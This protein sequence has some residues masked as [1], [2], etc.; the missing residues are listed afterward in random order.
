MVADFAGAEKPPAGDE[1]ENAAEPRLAFN[2]RFAPWKT[3]LER[4]AEVAKLN[5]DMDEPPPGT[6]NYYDKSTYS[7]KE[8]LDIIN[9][10]LI[11]K[12]FILVRRDRFLVVANF[13]R[14]PVPPNL[15]PTVALSELPKRGKNEYLSV[16]IPL[17][18][19]DAKTASEEIKDLL[20]PY[21]Q[22]KA[23]P[24]V[25]SN[26]LIVTDLASHVQAIYEVLEGM[27][28]VT[29][30]KGMTVRSFKLLHI[31]ATEAERMLRDL[32]SL[33]A[34]GAAS[35]STASEPQQGAAARSSRQNGDDTSRRDWW[36]R[37]R[38][39]DDRFSRGGGGFPGSGDFT[40][41]GE[42]G[43]GEPQAMYEQF[44][45]RR[46]RGGRGSDGGESGDQQGASRMTLT[47]DPRQNTLLVTCSVEDMRR[48]E[49]VIK[50]IDVEVSADARGDYLR[51]DNVPQ[52][53]VYPLE[54]AD[55]AVVAEVLYLT[56]PGLVVRDDAKT[57]GVIVYAT[58]TEQQQVRNIV[59]QLDGQV[60]DSIA[61]L[62]LRHWDAAAAATSLK[63]LFE[64]TKVDPPTIEADSNGRRLM[65]R[66]TPDQVSQIKRLLADMGEDGSVAAP[67][68]S[69]TGPVRSILPQGRSAAEILAIVKQ[70]YPD[71][72]NSSIR[73]VEPSAIGVPSFQLRQIDA[74]RRGGSPQFRRVAPPAGPGPAA[75][76]SSGFRPESGGDSG[77]GPESDGDASRRKGKAPAA[78]ERRFPFAAYRD[79]KAAFGGT[80]AVREKSVG[81]PS[82][83]APRPQTGK[84]EAGIEELSRQL[85]EALRDQEKSQQA[86]GGQESPENDEP[87]A[88]APASTP[89][90]KAGAE[91]GPSGELRM[92]VFGDRILI[93]STDTKALDRM[94]QL[95]Q[96]L[97]AAAPPKT[98]WTVYYLRVADAAETATMLG[99][100]FPQGT[101]KTTQTT[102]GGFFSRFNTSNDS[103]TLSSLSKGGAL[104]IIPEV[105]SNA[106]FISGDEHEVDQ[107][108]E[109]LRVL[110]SSELPESLKDR[111]PRMIAVEHADVTEV[112]AI[113]RDVYKE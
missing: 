7:V 16:V 90:P 65:V 50:T 25:A 10:Y 11:Q 4:F 46:D 38:G 24:M 80:P 36:R 101:V 37:G 64:S 67:S 88:A 66:G 42:S 71:T 1:K 48:V 82:R 59:K 61:S 17:A 5:L 85:E 105:R 99:S 40:R 91:S 93:A 109:A 44:M 81:A 26:K 55:P 79:S 12:G 63:A 68:T 58:R 75:D 113:V 84:D 56:V 31:S 107:V 95:I 100:L 15:I 102:G 2:F 76:D 51:G 14:G 74:P 83:A 41:G 108:M 18:N 72:E 89:A 22:G 34:R 97:S 20:G 27:G 78:G 3:V 39:G 52:L 96:M 13:G 54:N 21:P 69:G 104:R 111:V 53:E 98:K 73:I 62:Q 94:E 86:D 23:I 45:N 33:P 103:A 30:D 47:I 43:G 8:A 112:A 87:A 77:A 49:E 92:T 110:D 32:F 57:R 28:K 70:I 29:P 6:F 35:R 106:L 19:I 60:G 9:G